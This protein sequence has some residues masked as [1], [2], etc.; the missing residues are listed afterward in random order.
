[1]DHHHRERVVEYAIRNLDGDPYVPGERGLSGGAGTQGQVNMWALIVQLFFIN[2]KSNVTRLDLMHAST[3]RQQWQVVCPSSMVAYVQRWGMVR[4]FRQVE[5]LLMGMTSYPLL[6]GKV[7]V[8][9]EAIRRWNHVQMSRMVGR[10]RQ[11]G[12]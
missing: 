3:W 10:S 6:A 12:C 11:V 8:V 1:M 5:H 4:R 7:L 9:C 2:I